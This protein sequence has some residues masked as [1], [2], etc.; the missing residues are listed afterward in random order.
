MLKKISWWLFAA[1]CIFIGLY[2]ITYFV[3]DR[4]FGLL[5]TKTS[6]LLG[7]LTWNIAFYGH[8]VFGGIVLLIGWTQFSGWVRKN[9]MHLHRLIGK[10][11]II[12]VLI[13]GLCGI[14]IGIYATGGLIA[15]SAFIGLGIVW[16]SSTI[17]AYL[18]I[19][20]K[21]KVNHQYAMII[22]YALCFSAVTLRIWLPILTNVYGGFTA[23]YPTVA[24]VSWVPN[25]IVA[26]GIIYYMEQRRKESFLNNV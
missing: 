6:E 22:S 17:M 9:K 19:I 11:Y 3:I 25:F 20:N 1:M 26:L 16:L 4:N 15:Q 21:K 8:I 7:D 23:A 14:Y 10:I 13:S 2:P 5:S 18:Y 12:G 24:W